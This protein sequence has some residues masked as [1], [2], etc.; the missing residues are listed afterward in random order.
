MIDHDSPSACHNQPADLS[1][2]QHQYLERLQTKVHIP[3][4]LNACRYILLCAK[5]NTFIE[6]RKFEN[7]HFRFSANLR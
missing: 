3:W 6:I 1:K 4:L 7:N 5:I 2:Y